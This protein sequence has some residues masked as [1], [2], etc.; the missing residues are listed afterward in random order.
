MMIRWSV[1]LHSTLSLSLVAFIFGSTPE[2]VRT[3]HFSSIPI[4][5]YSSVTLSLFNVSRS[6]VFSVFSFVLY[7]KKK[8]KD[9]NH[10]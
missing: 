8:K 1:G 4:L 9:Q 10:F 3:L 2:F 5:T 7:K 6:L